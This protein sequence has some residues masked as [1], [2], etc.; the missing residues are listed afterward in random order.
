MSAYFFCLSFV[1][2]SA[3]PMLIYESWIGDLA[4]ENNT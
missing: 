1:L 3:D 4:N 2:I